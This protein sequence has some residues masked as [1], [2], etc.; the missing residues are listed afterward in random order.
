[1]IEA[2]LCMLFLG[3]PAPDWLTFFLRTETVFTMKMCSLCCL[4]SLKWH[5][6]CKAE[7]S[8]S[9]SLFFFFLLVAKRARQ[10]HIHRNAWW[11][12]KAWGQSVAAE[13]AA[14]STS[15]SAASSTDSRGAGVPQSATWSDKKLKR[16]QIWDQWSN[17]FSWLVMDDDLTMYCQ[18]YLQHHCLTISGSLQALLPKVIWPIPGFFAGCVNH[19]KGYFKISSAVQ[20][21][22]KTGLGRCDGIS[23]VVDVWFDCCPDNCG[24]RGAPHAQRVAVSVAAGS[25]S[26]PGVCRHCQES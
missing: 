4:L 26:I 10:R 13:T 3:T 22:M 15:S 21:G 8:I 16:D 23:A 19:F 12:N 5:N 1:M 25:P 6:A 24:R 11:V 17:D 9:L 2:E 18:V 7:L 20:G 14:P